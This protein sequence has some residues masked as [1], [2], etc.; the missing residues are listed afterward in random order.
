MAVTANSPNRVS[1]SIE[2]RCW[3]AACGCRMPSSAWA[4]AIRVPN[5]VTSGAG[6]R[7]RP[8]T[9]RA[10][11]E[12]RPTTCF[13]SGQTKQFN[14]SNQVPGSEEIRSRFTVGMLVRRMERG[15]IAEGHGQAQLS[16]R[17][18]IL[19]AKHRV[20]IVAARVEP[21][22]RRAFTVQRLAAGVGAQSETRAERGRQHLHRTKRGLGDRPEARVGL[23]GGVAI[24]PI[25]GRLPTV[26]FRI[27]PRC[28]RD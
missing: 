12:S 7:A 8:R 17:T 26:K 18:G 13:T 2:S 25:I 14:G 27:D 16:P 20:R 24:G 21:G 9:S 15:E 3:L 23:V 19:P 22:N 1:A 11:T 5:P 28:R 4:K 10:G 6:L